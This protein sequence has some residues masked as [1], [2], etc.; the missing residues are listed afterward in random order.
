[1][2]WIWPNDNKW[3]N[4]TGYTELLDMGVGGINAASPRVAVDAL[5]AWVPK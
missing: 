1:M 2:L 5:R 3:E 4:Q